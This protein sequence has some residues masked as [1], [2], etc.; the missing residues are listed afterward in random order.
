MRALHVGAISV[1]LGSGLLYLVTRPT[2]GQE[3][4]GGVR[5]EYGSTMRM[6]VGRSFMVSVASGAFLL[7]DRLANPRLGLVYVGVL[8]AKLAI[9]VGIAWILSVRPRRAHAQV[10][11]APRPRWSDP[12][13]QALALGVVALLL[14]V[15]LTLIYEAQAGVS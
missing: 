4:S 6:L 8:A 7:F 14:G 11:G 1:W 13:W 5:K 10:D 12:G 3:A 2:I 9:V 15:V